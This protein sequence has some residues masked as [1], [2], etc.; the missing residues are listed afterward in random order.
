MSR[1]RSNDKRD[2]SDY[3]ENIMKGISTL[4]RSKSD[5]L[6][7]MNGIICCDNFIAVPRILRGIR[8]NT[9][10]LR[11]VPVAKKKRRATR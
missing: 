3:G 8:V 5:E 1:Q 2:P 7:R 9:S 4:R 6:K 11:R 10:R